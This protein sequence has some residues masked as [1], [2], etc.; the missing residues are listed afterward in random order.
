[1]KTTLQL[2][3]KSKSMLRKMPDLVV[4]AVHKGMKKVMVMVER[5]VKG[6]Y[7]SG[8]ALN[9]RTGR[10]RN[11]ITHDETISGNR[12]EGRIGTNVVYGRFWELGY[13]GPVS[14]KSHTRKISQAF[15]RPIKPV[16]VNVSAHTRQVNVKARPFLRPAIEDVKPKMEK[17]IEKEITDAF[18]GVS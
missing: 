16:N 3:N 14:V 4:P 10:L 15:G 9:R 18:E 5:E 17:I 13:T 11:S 7:L 12:V 1:M 6:N 8:G 2:S